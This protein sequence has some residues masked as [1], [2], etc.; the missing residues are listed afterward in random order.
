MPAQS[1][2]ALGSSLL[3]DSDYSFSD[4]HLFAS[5]RRDLSDHPPARWAERYHAEWPMGGRSLHRYIP[6]DGRANLVARR[7]HPRIDCGDDLSRRNGICSCLHSDRRQGA[8][9]S[10]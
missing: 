6:H 3:P 5:K 8:G 1:V 2:S 9:S 4:D 10:S 7:D